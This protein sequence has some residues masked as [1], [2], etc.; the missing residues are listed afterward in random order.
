MPSRVLLLAALTLACAAEPA[1]VTI[2]AAGPWKEGYGA[3]NKRG[4]DLAVSEINSAGGVRGHPLRV[5]ERDD[6]GDGARAAAIAQQFVLDAAISAVVGHVNSGAM[7]AAAKVYDGRLAAVATTATSPDL[8]GISPW[9]FRVIGSDSASGVQLAHFA[10]RLDASRVAILY[11]NDSYGR[12]LAE[13]FRRNFDGAVLSVDPIPGGGS[14]DFEPYVA[15]LLDRRPEIVFVAGTEASGMALLREARRQKLN[16]DFLGGDGW[17]GIIDEPA[18]EGAFVGSPFTASDPRPEAQRF[19]A[20]F[21]ARYGMLP[22]ANAALAYDATRLL[23]RVIDDVG[24]DRRAIRDR[25]AAL[26]DRTAHLGATG[27]IRFLSTGDRVTTAL[28][29]ARVDNGELI[30]TRGR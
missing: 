2:G 19:V 24:P 30:V 10:R 9:V 7:V 15:Y 20:A 4:I 6:A 11:E 21:R 1:T 17:A 8:T 12:G 5:V 26:D 3:M 23:A 29:I 25:L 16:A 27:A 18:A 14:T 22:D 28:L 13:A